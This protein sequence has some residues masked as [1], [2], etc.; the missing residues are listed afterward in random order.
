MISLQNPNLDPKGRP[1]IPNDKIK[2]IMPFLRPYEHGPF[3][4]VNKLKPTILNKNI[5]VFKF[6]VCNPKV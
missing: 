5:N 1:M 6:K 3:L 2:K 4:E